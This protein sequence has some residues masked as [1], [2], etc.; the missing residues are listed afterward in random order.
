MAPTRLL[1]EGPDIDELLERVRDEHGPGV[2]IVNADKLRSGGV[3]GFFAREKFAVTIEVADVP[4]ADAT[5]P[6][7]AKQTPRA[8]AAPG[9]LL[10]LADAIDAAEA[11]EATVAMGTAD[12]STSNRTRPVVDGAPAA[13]VVP[14]GLGPI[15]TEG[16]KFAEVLAGLAQTTQPGAPAVMAPGQSDLFVPAQIA[17]A[18]PT[19]PGPRPAVSP[20]PGATVAMPVETYS[21][22]GRRRRTAETGATAAATTAGTVVGTIAPGNS[23]ALTTAGGN[24]LV[25]RLLE[26]GLPEEL[27]ARLQTAGVGNLRDNL[28]R[29]LKDRPLPA[30]SDLQAGDVLVIAGPGQAAYEVACDVSRRLRLDP[31]D[32]L[33]AAPSTLGL[34]IE[35][36]ARISGPVDARRRSGQLRR[37]DVPTVVAVDVAC[38][39][40]SA[41]WG[42][43]IADA[44]G[45]R[46]MWAIVDATS[47]PGDLLDHL[48]ALG[49]LDGLVV[50]GST[51]SRDPGSVLHPALRLALPTVLLDGGP[52][53]AEAWADLLIERIG[54]L[55]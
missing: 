53:D 4:A 30:T 2:R 23:A 46:V 47:K 26:L 14:A 12:M 10:E 29:V 8:V 7:P 13:P 18:T 22:A 35:A 39:R 6:K 19:T 17:K 38:D 11:A 45:A 21:P 5:Q 49:R 33:L 3:A 51:A 41:S 32:V 27:C 20:A 24:P 43:A 25:R 37:A 48:T 31:A 1:L 9:T 40:E 28:V 16:A 15:S 34:R 52:G 50:R 42:R 54:D 36:E 55:S 44:L